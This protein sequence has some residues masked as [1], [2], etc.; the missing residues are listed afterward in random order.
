[1]MRKTL[2]ILAVQF[3]MLAALLTLALDS[4]EHAQ[5]ETTLG[6]NRWGYRGAVAKQ[7][8]YDETRIMVVGGTSAFEPQRVLL[9]TVTAR[10]RYM[11]QQWVTL[12]R[13][14]VTGVNIAAL[15]LP[16]GAYA[17]R[18]R[19]FSYLRPDAICVVVDL[20]PAGE[21]PVDGLLARTTGYVPALRPVTAIDQWLGS[22]TGRA[23]TAND[24][25]ESIG[26]VVSTAS[27]LAPTVVAIPQPSSEDERVTRDVVRRTLRV[28]AGN[29]RVKIVELIDGPE[30]VV[31]GVPQ[32]A[33]AAQ[34]E[35]ALSALL[36]ERS[37]S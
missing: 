4:F 10:L 37:T 14:P 29:A 21:A 5:T 15:R 3:V 27:A 1:M 22:V 35:P 33:A 31:R 8:A 17:E 32:P 30:V 6:V 16:R 25:A 13:G 20:A 9:D 28:Y 18:L 2:I 12:D 36:R 7:R 11:V 23:A 26:E 24:A 19:R 34:I